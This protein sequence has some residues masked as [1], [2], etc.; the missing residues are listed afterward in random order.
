MNKN[1]I[2]NS[3]TLC[4]DVNAINSWKA[5]SKRQR[6]REHRLFFFIEHFISIYKYKIIFK[7]LIASANVIHTL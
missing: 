4:D 1:I 3:L 2:D 6:E 7:F 5:W